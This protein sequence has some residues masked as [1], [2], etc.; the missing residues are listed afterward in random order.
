MIPVVVCHVTTST[1]SDSISSGFAFKS[2]ALLAPR[3]AC[4]LFGGYGRA[5]VKSSG[6]TEK[7]HGGR[8]EAARRRT[9]RAEGTDPRSLWIREEVGCRLQEGGTP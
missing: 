3:S 4:I 7:R 8:H 6:T 5:A 1:A 9:R 2:V